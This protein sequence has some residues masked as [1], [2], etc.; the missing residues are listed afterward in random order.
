LYKDYGTGSIF[1]HRMQNN[2]SFWAVQR[3]ASKSHVS[4]Y[5][6]PFSMGN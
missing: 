5:L 6:I 1:L 4:S 2:D 3:Y